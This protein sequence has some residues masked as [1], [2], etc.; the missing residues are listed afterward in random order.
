MYHFKNADSNISKHS[1]NS[2]EEEAEAG[3][4]CCCRICNG[5]IC[6]IRICDGRICNGNPISLPMHKYYVSYIWSEY[7]FGCQ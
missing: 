7:V 1:L 2:E 5:R 3:S 6:N 4:S